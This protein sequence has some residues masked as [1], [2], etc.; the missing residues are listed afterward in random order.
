TMK[1]GIQRSLVDLEHVLR[2][3]LDALGDRPA[4]LRF[5]LKRTKDQEVERALEKVEL[6]RLWRHSVECRLQSIAPLVS[7]VNTNR[8]AGGL[9][10]M[11]PEEGDHPL[12]RIEAEFR[13]D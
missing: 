5:L 10:E 2:H 9:R 11:A 4:V 1:C 6:S 13:R 12:E 8:I 3:L 7:N